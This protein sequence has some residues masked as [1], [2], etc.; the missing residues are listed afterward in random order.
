MS[1]PPL[2]CER[3][4]AE[5]HPGRGDLYR[6]TIEAVADPFPPIID[7]N[8]LRDPSRELDQI[9]AQAAHLT[10]QELVDQVYRKVTFYLCLRCCRTWIENPTAS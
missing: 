9:V 8:L 4:R 7:E 1:E 10:E 3:C 5:L 6:V 2:W